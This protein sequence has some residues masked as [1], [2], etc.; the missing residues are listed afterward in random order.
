M[1]PVVTAEARDR[2]RGYI[3]QGVQ[4]GATAV[5]DGREL[6]LEVRN[7]PGRAVAASDGGHGL[8]GMRERVRIFDGR[9]EAGA[10]ADGGFRVYAVLPLGDEG[11]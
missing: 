10:A 9:F 4:D 2:I 8:I 1:G 5:V 11:A 3:D 7:G 6:A